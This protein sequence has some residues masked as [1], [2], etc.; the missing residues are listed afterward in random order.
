MKEK[1]DLLRTKQTKNPRNGML[2]AHSV[3]LKDEEN[4]GETYIGSI[5]KS[6]DGWL[7]TAVDPAHKLPGERP[8]KNENFVR[9]EGFFADKSQALERLHKA[10]LFT[11]K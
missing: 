10:H 6:E 5:L 2:E 7:Y 3:F 8:P 11:L 9:S 4:G 1:S